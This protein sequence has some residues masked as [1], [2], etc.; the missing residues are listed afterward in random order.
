MN[1]TINELKSSHFLD[2]KIANGLLSLEA[3]TP[4]FKMFPKVHK[5]ENLG[6]PV[7]SSINCHTKKVS[8]YIDNQ[9][10]PYVKKKSHTCE[11]GG[12]H[13]RISF[14]HLLMNLKKKFIIKK[15]V[16]VGQ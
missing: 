4:K 2:E 8:K 6:R 1:R 15:T 7:V 3:Q 10:Q 9:L 11:E 5:K 16:E 13:I 14:W 12:A